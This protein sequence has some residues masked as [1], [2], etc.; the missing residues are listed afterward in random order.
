MAKMIQDLEVLLTFFVFTTGKANY[1]FLGTLFF[2]F[3]NRELCR[4]LFDT[5][6]T[7]QWHILHTHLVAAQFINATALIAHSDFIATPNMNRL[8][9]GTETEKKLSFK[10]CNFLGREKTLQIA[11][12]ADIIISAM[13][14][15]E[16][17]ANEAEGV[18]RWGR[19]NLTIFRQTK[20]EQNS[21]ANP[22]TSHVPL[23]SLP[24]AAEQISSAVTHIFCDVK[25]MLVGTQKKQNRDKPLCRWLISSGVWASEPAWRS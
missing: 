2:M 3:C 20:T 18:N 9:L 1:P 17:E 13:L 8:V 25:K 4:M 7:S 22:S 21:P 15:A 12:G 10:M 14:Q 11:R 23:R 5:K 16:R 19:C 24:T 6:C